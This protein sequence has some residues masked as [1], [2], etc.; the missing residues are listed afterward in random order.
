[1]A[2]AGPE[3]QCWDA[4]LV[5]Y[6]PD[7]HRRY[8]RG[9]GHPLAVGGWIF[10]CHDIGVLSCFEPRTGEVRYAERIVKLGEGF[11][12]SPVS[13]GRHLYFASEP[14]NVYVVP[15]ADKFSVAATNHM[16]ETCMA[17]PAITLVM[18]FD[19]ERKSY[20]RSAP[21]P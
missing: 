9:D 20:G 10:A 17:T 6:M 2:S 11:T 7:H 3:R 4:D 14:G 8:D 15:V 16:E 18:V 13:D 1:M 21:N 12:A 19:A 5:A